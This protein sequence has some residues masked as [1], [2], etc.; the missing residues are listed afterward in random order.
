MFHFVAAKCHLDLG[1]FKILINHLRYSV[2]GRRFLGLRNL[3][4][5][6]RDQSLHRLLTLKM[7]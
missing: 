7:I 1:M 3:G 5:I 4:I 6:H 2:V